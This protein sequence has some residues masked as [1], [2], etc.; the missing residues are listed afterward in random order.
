[1]YGPA[2]TGSNHGM[3]VLRG[4][5]ELVKLWIV[6]GVACHYSRKEGRFEFEIE[7][8]FRFI[9]GRYWLLLCL[10]VVT[11]PKDSGDSKMTHNPL[12]IKDES[13]SICRIQTGWSLPSYLQGPRVSTH[14][15][16][17]FFG[18]YIPWFNIE[19][20]YSGKTP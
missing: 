5:S 4:R 6:V 3:Y 12:L 9:C 17:L 8:A 20:G 13:H 10:Q 18:H 2:K 16:G 14:R 1:M 11:L 7:A 15:S 19:L